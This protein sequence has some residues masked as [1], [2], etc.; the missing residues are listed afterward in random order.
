MAKLGGWEIEEMRG[1]NLPQ[2]AASAFY[3]VMSGMT[4]AEY[5]PVLYV[6]KQ[7][8]NGTNY[9]VL[10]IQTMVTAQPIKRLVKLVLNESLDGK[11]SLVSISVI[12]L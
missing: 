9:C 5:Q 3:E 6:G 7:I 11:Y 1:G 2:K 12:P 10:A 4:G 8:V